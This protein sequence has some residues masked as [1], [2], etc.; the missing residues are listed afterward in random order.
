VNLME[1]ILALFLLVWRC[2]IPLDLDWNEH[3]LRLNLMTEIG[4]VDGNLIFDGVVGL[5]RDESLDH[6]LWDLF[7]GELMLQKLLVGDLMMFLMRN[8]CLGFGLVLD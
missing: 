8:L 6:F 1:L 2:L 5:C 3:Q 4:R 7:L